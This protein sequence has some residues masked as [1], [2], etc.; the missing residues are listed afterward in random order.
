MPP[1]LTILNLLLAVR[2][3]CRHRRHQDAEVPEVAVDHAGDAVAVWDRYNGSDCIGQAGGY[4][5]AERQL[6]GLEIPAAGTAGVPV[7]VPFTPRCALGDHA[8]RGRLTHELGTV[9]QARR[10]RSGR[11][12]RAVRRAT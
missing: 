2:C 12:W 9:R 4:D 7:E 1:T 6:H 5:F 11:A 3:G 8:V 10:G